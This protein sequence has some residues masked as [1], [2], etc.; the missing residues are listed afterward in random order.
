MD[1]WDL[2]GGTL[3]RARSGQ[4]DIEHIFAQHNESRP[5]F[6]RLLFLAV[7]T[8]ARGQ[9]G[10]FLL[11]GFSLACL[12]SWS[13]FHLARATI[14]ANPSPLWGLTFLA[15][16][17]IFTPKQAETW[18]WSSYLGHT[19]SSSSGRPWDRTT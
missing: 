19:W 11:I 18:L 16:L 4:L 7:G 13:V 17:L 12:V 14:T 1:D 2:I 15:N 8:V 6:P 5:L 3:L 10:W 9:T